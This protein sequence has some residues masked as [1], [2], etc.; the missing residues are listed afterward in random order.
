MS[1]VLRPSTVGRYTVGVGN[2]GSSSLGSRNFSGTNMSGTSGSVGPTSS[3]SSSSASGAASGVAAVAGRDFGDLSDMIR[4]GMDISAN[5]TAQSQAFAREQMEWQEEQNQKAM[6][7]SA[8][9]AQLNR[10]W[11]ERLSNTAHQREVDDLL[12]AGLNPVLSA[13]AGAYTG[14]GATASGVTSS[15]AKGEVDTTVN[16]LVGQLISASINTAANK[17]VAELYTD[18]SRYQADMSY[19]EAKLASETSIYNNHNTNA[20]NKAI[21]NMNANATISSANAHAA[22]SR[23]ASDN[24]LA[25]SKYASDT[26][27]ENTKSTNKTSIDVAKENH[28]NSYQGSVKQFSEEFANNS[29]PSLAKGAES[30][31]GSLTDVLKNLTYSF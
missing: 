24:S 22:A 27:R 25:A 18:A 16:G 31:F 21:G 15:G 11:Q 6:D 17:A 29:I 3:G 1:N 2:T 12:K 13:N 19:A 20:A 5:N 28:W 8:K 10:D 30:F 4:A 7:F 26:G 14:S 9:Q 23:Y